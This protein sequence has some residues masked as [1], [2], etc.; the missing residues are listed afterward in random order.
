M[1]SQGLDAQ[2]YNQEVEMIQVEHSLS[3]LDTTNDRTVLGEKKVWLLDS[4]CSQH[5]SGDAALFEDLTPMNH[6]VSIKFGDGKFLQAK[7]SGQVTTPLGRLRAIFVPN[8]CANLLSVHQLNLSGASVCFLPNHAEI[9]LDGKTFPVTMIGN[10]FQL[11][12]LCCASIHTDDLQI[13]HQRLGHLHYDAVVLYLRRFG[14]E[15]SKVSDAPCKVCIQAKLCEKKFKSRSHYSQNKLERIHSDIGGP[16]QPSYDGY[17]Y[18]ITYIDEYS[19]FAKVELLSSKSEAASATISNLKNLKNVAQCG[20][21]IFR[22]DGGA[23][24]QSITL[25]QYFDEQGINHEVVPPYTPQL[26]G[27]AERLNRTLVEKIRCLLI[28]SGL[29][30]SFWADAMNYACYIYNRTPHSALEFKTPW[31]VFHDTHFE[32]MPD[33]H[34]FGSVAFYHVASEH[35]RKLDATAKKCI[36]LG[37]SNTS[38]RILCLED[39]KI[40]QVRTVKVLDGEFLEHSELKKLGFLINSAV[41]SDVCVEKF[42]TANPVTHGNSNYERPTE[43]VSSDQIDAFND[44]SEGATLESILDND[45]EDLVPSEVEGGLE[46]EESTLPSLDSSADSNSSRNSIAYVEQDIEWHPSF[47]KRFAHESYDPSWSDDSSNELSSYLCTEGTKG[48]LYLGNGKN[49]LCF[50]SSEE[51][52][53]DEPTSFEDASKD[54]RWVQSMREE[55][56]SLLDQE[57]WELVDLP[58]ERKIVKNRWVYKKKSDGRLKSRLVAKGFT[59]TYGLDYDE[60]WSPV[61]RKSSL[62]LLISH[63]INKKWSWRQMDVDTAFLNSSLN[64]EIYMSQPVG[65]EDGTSRVCRLLKSVYG[66]KQA[67]REWYNTLG[68]FLHSLDFTRSRIDPCL[69]IR[70][71]IIIFIY[72]DDIIIAARDQELVDD[73]AENF[74][75]RFRMK[76]MGR[77]RRILGLDIS[78]GDE[79]IHLSSKG[80]ID[81][82]LKKYQFE[83]SRHVATPMDHNQT[84]IPNE[85]DKASVEDQKMFSSLMGSLLYIA[86]TFRPDISYSVSVLS[87]FTSNPSNDHIRAVKRILRYLNGTRDYGLIFTKDQKENSDLRGYTDADFASCSSRK[88]RTGYAFKVGNSVLSW[89]SKKQSVIA[90]STCEAEYYALTEGGKEAIHLNRLL[91]EF[92][93]Q[94]PIC[95]ETILQSVKLFCDNQ[96]TIFVSKNPAEHKVMKH[97]DLRMKWIQEKVESGNFVIEYISSKEQVA[98]ILTKPLPKETFEKLRE[99]C[100]VTR[101]PAITA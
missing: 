65:F 81:D 15:C 43:N 1:P 11:E 83:N 50:N 68:E 89:G 73:I 7:G 75:R 32:V 79:W 12:E 54:P 77:P 46:L 37:Y 40:K 87:Q 98:D 67:S 58:P 3:S 84:F 93:H 90:L 55:M 99:S 69:F 96:S 76:D 47:G 51:I 61:G 24:Y 60:T 17:K 101:Q 19:R 80:M 20:I 33:F 63:V 18:W 97:L 9:R 82:L 27:M 74:K 57:T 95:D 52:S 78:E 5:M 44:I 39:L 71:G 8:L 59:Q 38:T 34:S 13:W 25:Q 94:K 72:V 88:S 100:A 45:N 22:S 14:I 4:C 66:L 91:W 49:L 56:K 48:K 23:E 30:F 86:N 31:E 85:D 2:G 42:V 21:S 29:N 36:F 26:N 92:E 41:I 62:R 28:S 35:R 53:F 16:I 70:P 64:E 10:I 6:V